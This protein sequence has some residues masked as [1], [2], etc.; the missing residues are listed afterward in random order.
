MSLKKMNPK[1]GDSS[2]QFGK[3]PQSIAPKDYFSA[4]EYKPSKNLY[5]CAY[6]NS[7]YVKI[8]ANPYHDVFSPQSY[9]FSSGELVEA[10]KEYYFKI[11]PITW[12]VLLDGN[13]NTMLFVLVI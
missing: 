13:L 1:L 5:H 7:D 4:M 2:I 10:G 12:I 8:I 11:E 6:D 3:Y 9:H